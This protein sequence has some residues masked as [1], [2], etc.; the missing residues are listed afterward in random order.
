[1]E[2]IIIIKL[3]Q[4]K[5]LGA[6]YRY[7]ILHTG[8]DGV[9]YRLYDGQAATANPSGVPFAF[10]PVLGNHDVTTDNGQP[11]LDTLVLAKDAVTTP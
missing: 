1:M 8:S 9:E 11:F 7:E 2:D 4:S 3:T 10:Y 5:L 6:A